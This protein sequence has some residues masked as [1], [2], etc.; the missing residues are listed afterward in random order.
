MFLTLSHLRASLENASKIVTKTLIKRALR[1]ISFE[2]DFFH[3]ADTQNGSQR[4]IRTPPETLLGAL[5][6][7]LGPSGALLDGLWVLLGRS[8]TLLGRSWDALGTLLDALG[9]LLDDFWTQLG[10]KA[11]FWAS[12]NPPWVDFGPLFGELS[13]D[14]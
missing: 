4:P 14:F 1:S 10:K 13:V 6:A 7:L 5:G 9:R 8:W 12:R 11:T 2:R 3:V